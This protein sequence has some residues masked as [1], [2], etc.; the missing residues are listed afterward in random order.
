M[1]AV[2]TSIDETTTDL[3]EWSLNRL[4]F[5][6]YIVKSQKTTLYQKLATIFDIEDIINEDFLRVDADV[7]VNR[8]VLEL[9]KQDKLWWYQAQCFDWFQQDVSHGGVQFIR[10]ECFPAIKKHLH[11]AERMER[12]E[13]YLSRLIE[14]HEPRRFGTFEKICGVHGYKQNDIERIKLTK[15]RRGQQD[16]YD[17][18]LAERLNAL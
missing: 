2:I 13:T 5:R 16:N 17:W 10:K 4:G 7:V 9:I 12:P 6:V 1:R 15:F 14:F 8:N 18:E 3:C 11:E